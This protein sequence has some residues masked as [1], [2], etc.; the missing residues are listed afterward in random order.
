MTVYICSCMYTVLLHI[1]TLK[2]ALH[3]HYILHTYIYAAILLYDYTILLDYYVL[4]TTTTLL[5]LIY[6]STTTNT[7]PPI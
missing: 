6:Y 3:L 7:I 5:E 4:Y 1:Y 2:I